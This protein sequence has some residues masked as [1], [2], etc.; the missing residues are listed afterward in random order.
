MPCRASLETDAAMRVS[1]AHPLHVARRSAVAAVLYAGKKQKIQASIEAVFNVAVST[2]EDSATNVH[3]AAG[4]CVCVCV[5]VYA[6]TH[7]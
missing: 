1:P 5:C 4:V 3:G 2:A 6:R 7:S